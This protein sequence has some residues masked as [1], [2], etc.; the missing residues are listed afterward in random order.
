[1]VFFSSAHMVAVFP[2][3]AILAACTSGVL[4]GSGGFCPAGDADCLASEVHGHT[5]DDLSVALQLRASADPPSGPSTPQPFQVAF[6]GPPTLAPSPSPK[7]S[8]PSTANKCTEMP[9]PNLVCVSLSDVAGPQAA[10]MITDATFGANSDIADKIMA[11]VLSYY[12]GEGL[13]SSQADLKLSNSVSG[14]RVRPSGLAS[15]LTANGVDKHSVTVETYATLMMEKGKDAALVKF[16]RGLGL[17]ANG[18]KTLNM[19]QQGQGIT[20]YSQLATANAEELT[21]GIPEGELTAAQSSI[22]RAAPPKKKTPTRDTMP[23]SDAALKRMEML[24]SA[25]DA[26]AAK[27]DQMRRDAEAKVAQ[28]NADT[29]KT[30]EQKAAAIQKALDQFQLSYADLSKTMAA[31]QAEMDKLTMRTGVDIAGS[32]LKVQELLQQLGIFRGVVISPTRPADS[33]QERMVMLKGQYKT[34]GAEPY[35]H[36]IL[37]KS[38]QMSYEVSMSFTD[39]HAAVTLS[40]GISKQV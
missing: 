16:N 20:A 26:Y 11:A 37:T 12:K 23:F 33:M 17:S 29:T 38:D 8:K 9:T 10:L 27:A 28:I 34:N 36:H 6:V 22:E 2:A 5:E 13:V 15:L 3:L 31:G 7:P 4:G 21:K 40:N 35:K 25:Q 1:M 14:M 19:N 18:Y 30:A 32:T 24:K 39:S